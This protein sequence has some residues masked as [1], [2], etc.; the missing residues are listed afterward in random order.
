MSKMKNTFFVKIRKRLNLQTNGIFYKYRTINFCNVNMLFFNK[1]VFCNCVIKRKIT[2]T[3]NFV[4][5]RKITIANNLATYMSSGYF[6]ANTLL[7]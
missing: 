3:N 2:I 1:H 4:I 6:I 7:V 5:K